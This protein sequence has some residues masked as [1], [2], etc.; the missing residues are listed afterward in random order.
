MKLFWNPQW[1]NL[2]SQDTTITCLLRQGSRRRLVSTLPR[3][4]TRTRGITR[5]VRV[6]RLRDLLKAKVLPKVNIVS[7]LYLDCALT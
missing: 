7:V 3:A 6:G 4:K 2:R 5:P 1:L